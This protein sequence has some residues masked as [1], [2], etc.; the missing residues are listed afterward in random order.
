VSLPGPIVS[1][2]DEIL[3]TLVQMCRPLTPPARIA[4]LEALAVLLRQEPQQPPGDGTVF[5]HARDLL[6]SR[7]A[8]ARGAEGGIFS[9]SE[10]R[11]P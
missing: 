2:S 1:L 5:R 3:T 11:K 7:T 4:F 10:I 6:R 9:R 8:A